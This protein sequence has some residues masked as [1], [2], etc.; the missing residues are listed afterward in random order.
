VN[1][2]T[3]GS[4]YSPAVGADGDGNFV[5][6]WSSDVG[7]AASLGVFAQRYDALGAPVGGEIPVNEFT[8]GAQAQPVVAVDPTGGFVV[9]WTDTLRDGNGFGLFG[10]AFDASG[11]PLGA[12]FAVNTY[13]TGLQA[14]PAAAPTGGGHFVATWSSANQDGDN[15]GVFGQR[16]APDT[17]FRDDFET[18]DLSAWSGSQTDSGD[19]NASS[20]AALKFTT[21]GLQAVVDDTAGL[22]V[23]D[24]SPDDEGAYRAR[25]YFDT[26]GFDPGEALAHRRVRLFLA[27]EEAPLRRLAAVVLRRLGGAY[28]VMLRARLDDNSQSDSSFYPISDGAHFVELAWT[29]SS[30]PDANDGTFALWI[31]GTPVF[32]GSG[33]DNSLSGVDL[34]RLGALSVKTGAAGT[35]YLDEFVSHRVNPIGP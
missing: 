14:V 9:A 18:G 30:G 13:T 28:S 27:F 19:L 26:H 15:F 21:A 35:L 17:I 6:T 32:A 12:D 22:Y 10:R 7:G 2:V 25:F 20:S 24:G 34:V 23:E 33:I 29:R 5:V 4:Q 8:T 16:F 31:D 1:T 3:T 11:T